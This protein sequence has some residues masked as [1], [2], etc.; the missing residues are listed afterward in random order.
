MTI[1]RSSFLALAVAFGFVRDTLWADV[2]PSYVN[3][4]N[5]IPS[6]RYDAA[7]PII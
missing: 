5:K 2:P 4:S 7:G 6:K 3:T 1:F